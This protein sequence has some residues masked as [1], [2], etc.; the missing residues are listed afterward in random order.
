M[1]RVGDQ[2]SCDEAMYKTDQRVLHAAGAVE[3]AAMA[4]GVAMGI[5]HMGCIRPH[6]P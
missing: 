2:I 3:M 1:L 4:D 5:H 6:Y